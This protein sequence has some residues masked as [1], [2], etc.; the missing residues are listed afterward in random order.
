MKFQQI[1]TKKIYEEII[2]QIRILIAKG[3][4]KPGDKLPSE[5][6]LSESL[7][8]S[9]ASVREAL[10]ALEVLGIV[11]VRPGEGTFVREVV[12][13]SF[14]PLT[15]LFLLDT[16]LELLEVRKILE[17]GAVALAAERSTAED[18][19]R[20]E[21]ALKKMEED[22]KHGDLGDEADYL[23][24]YD[25]ALASHNSLLVRLMNSIADTM[26]QTVKINRQR[27]FKTPGMPESLYKHHLEI[28]NAIKARD[29]ER[30][31]KALVEH[32][33]VAEEKMLEE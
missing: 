4:L 16:A 8:V 27:L 25:L 5:R 23:F 29:K 13:K 7:G 31:Q 19:R 18:I 28:L 22:L 3:E 15:L 30:A 14:Q 9:R 11:E 32:L 21:D 10:S 6:E 12:E 20:L 1:K 2:E 17:A 33:T 26:R 24:H